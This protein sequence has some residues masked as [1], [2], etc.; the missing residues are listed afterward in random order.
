MEQVRCFIAIELPDELKIEI[1]RIQAKLKSDGQAG[2]KWVDPD[3]IHLTLKFLGEVD[4][5]WI[6]EIAG[7]MGAAVM[8]IS[9]FR[10]EVKGLGVF[11]NLNRV[12][13]V[14]VGLEGEVSKL[15]ELVQRIEANV[16]P[17]GFP[18]ESRPFT[19]HLTLARVGDR[20]PPDERQE[21]GQL[22]ARTKFE[23]KSAI[24]VRAVNLMKS[25]LTPQ[26]AIYSH[27]RSVELKG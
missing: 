21:L 18:T 7:A 3:G 23:A 12:R 15:L 4:A 6:D 20:V 17:L 27:L 10:L 16:S 1:K 2:V 11:P 19:P 14:W 5:D 26:G 22:V 9:P 8:G 13:V 24:E 25:Q